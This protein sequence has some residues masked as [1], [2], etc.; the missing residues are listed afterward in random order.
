[1]KIGLFIPC[2]VDQ[3]F[4]DVGDSVVELLERLDQEIDYPTEQT[5]CGMP[6]YNMGH[7]DAAQGP[8]KHFIDVFEDYDAVV[9]PSSSCAAMVK[10]YY[11]RLFADEASTLE[12]AQ[13]LAA[14]THE[15]TGFIVDEL[16]AEDV[17]ASFDGSVACHRS[18]HL[19]EMGARD[20]A[21]RLI[22]AVDGCKFVALPRTEVC[23][24][25]GGSFSVKFPVLSGAL[26]ESKCE[27]IEQCKADCV[28]TTDAGCM[29]QINGTLHRGGSQRRVWHIAELL[30]GKVQ[31]E[32]AT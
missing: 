18:C 19:R 22:K 11:P 4:P 9:T 13:R 24:G 10:H 25:F 14:K 17:G 15:L 8:A 1:M 32:A 31:I 30:A 21:E 5:C 27:N 26:A 20:Q 2:L 23:C 7:W 12:R 29:M 28:V 3:F 6:F 16:G